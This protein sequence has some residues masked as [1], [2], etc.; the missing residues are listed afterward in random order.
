M[1]GMGILRAVD[2]AERR[3]LLHAPYTAQQLAPV[4]LL[5]R[6]AVDMPISCL[7]DGGARRTALSGAVDNEGHAVPYVKFGA[8]EGVGAVAWKARRNLLRKR[9]GSHGDK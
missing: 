8:P 6:G 5:A 9:L 7:V 1:V 4:T 3:F 2:P